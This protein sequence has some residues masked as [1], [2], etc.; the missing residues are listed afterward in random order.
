MSADFL[1]AKQSFIRGMG[2]IGNLGGE[3]LFNYSDSDDGADIKALFSDWQAVGDDIYG[4]LDEYARAI[5]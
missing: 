1:F 3:I 2:S 5:E 4:A